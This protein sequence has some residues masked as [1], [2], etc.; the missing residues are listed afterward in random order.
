[1]TK[2]QS[3]LLSGTEKTIEVVNSCIIA[4]EGPSMVNKMSLDL[5]EI[6]YDSVSVN[7][8]TLAPDVSPKPI[9]YGW[10]GTNLTFLLIRP[11]YEGANP[12]T[13]TGSSAFLE[14]YFEDQPTVKRYLTQLLVLTG[15]ENHRIPQVYLYNPTDYTVTVDIMMANLDPNEISTAIVPTYDEFSGLAYS[16][17][18]TD[19]IYGVGMTGSTQFEILDILGNV[20]LVIP[21]SQ[22]DVIEIEGSTLTITTNSIDP[23]KLNFLSNFNANQAISRMNWVMESTINRYL[24]PTY[25]TIDILA[26]VITFSG[27]TSMLLIDYGGTITKTNIINKLIESIVDDRDG[28]MNKLNVNLVIIDNGT[29][30]Q[31]D[32][33]TSVGNYSFIFTAKDIAENSV[34]ETKIIDI[35]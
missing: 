24:T 27:V 7:R 17:I 14:Y 23:V 33:I 35:G 32:E 11:N 25:P 8:M 16:A 12:Q 9:M 15:D 2:I 19:Q 10:L 28:V 1:M 22:I 3:T 20:Q 29:A 6:P 26:P 5:L 34:S 18:I 4:K 21:I 31:Y 13:C 30:V